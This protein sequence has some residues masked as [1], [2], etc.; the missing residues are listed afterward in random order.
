MCY[1][2]NA[3]LEEHARTMVME[4][5]PIH[6]QPIPVM[7]EYNDDIVVYET[8]AP[9]PVPDREVPEVD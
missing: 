7:V 9:N 5:Q 1:T 8:T 3:L 2:P 4:P 6:Q